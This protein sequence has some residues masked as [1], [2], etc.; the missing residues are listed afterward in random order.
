MEVHRLT[1]QLDVMHAQPDAHRACHH[2]LV[3]L[4]LT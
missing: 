3:M 2:R 4:A 1:Q